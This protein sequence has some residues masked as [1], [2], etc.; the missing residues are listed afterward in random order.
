MDTNISTLNKIDKEN[1]NEFKQ[2][3]KMKL[4]EIKQIS[5]YKNE[6]EG[7]ILANNILVDIST[8]IDLMDISLKKAIRTKDGFL[9]PISDFL[10]CKLIGD[11]SSIQGYALYNLKNESTRFLIDKQSKIY[12]IQ[13]LDNV[14]FYYQKVQNKLNSY[15][16]ESS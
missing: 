4:E 9:I 16:S 15:L 11:N 3:L 2:Y 8:K 10:W 12:H 13:K 1:F 7:Y 14:L 6:L 5:I